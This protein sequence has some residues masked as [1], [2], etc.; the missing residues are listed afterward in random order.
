MAAELDMHFQQ[1]LPIDGA[2][3]FLGAG[4]VHDDRLNAVV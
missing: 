4:L 3:H 2:H 1:V